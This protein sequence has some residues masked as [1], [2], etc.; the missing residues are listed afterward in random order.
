MLTHCLANR[1]RQKIHEN[2]H[3]MQYHLMLC[4][5]ASQINM[6]KEILCLGTFA[7]RVSHKMSL[8]AHANS[9]CAEKRTLEIGSS[10]VKSTQYMGIVLL[11]IRSFI[12]SFL[13]AKY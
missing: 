4:D 6:K 10:L 2:I 5:I 12:T 11:F 9:E 3:V 1:K 13:H 8:G 7:F